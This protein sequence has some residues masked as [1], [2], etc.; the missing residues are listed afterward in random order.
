MKVA[1]EKVEGLLMPS[2]SYRLVKN[3][4]G[5]VKKSFITVSENPGRY[6]FMEMMIRQIL[7]WVGERD[8]IKGYEDMPL[9]AAVIEDIESRGEKFPPRL[10]SWSAVNTLTETGSVEGLK[11][12]IREI[13][14][15]CEE[16][17]F[18]PNYM[19]YFN[20]EAAR[21]I[22]QAEKLSRKF[23]PNIELIDKVNSGVINSFISAYRVPGEDSGLDTNFLLV[24]QTFGD[25]D[26][27]LE[28]LREAGFGGCHVFGTFNLPSAMDIVQTGQIDILL[29]DKTLVGTE[30][31]NWLTDIAGSSTNPLVALV[32]YEDEHCLATC[33]KVLA[34]EEF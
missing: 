19:R 14:K 28:A 22:E 8:Y 15:A 2:F 1:I 10:S 6:E 31:R 4:V 18:N 23:D 16:E 32:H 11:L 30:P 26:T 12:A 9:I 5:L 3:G 17:G 25:V 33:L 29:M 34:E 20:F 24:N 21:A 7:T 13:R 27:W